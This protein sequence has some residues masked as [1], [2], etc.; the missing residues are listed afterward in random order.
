[1]SSVLE[2]IEGILGPQAPGPIPSFSKIHVI[3]VLDTLYRSGPMGRASLARAVGLGEGAIRTMLGRL[4]SAGLVEVSRRGCRLTEE[5]LELWRSLSSR[6]VRLGEVERAPVGARGFA[7]LV[8][9]GAGRVRLGVEQ[10]DEAVR[11]GA[12][13]AIT[14]VVR[15]GKLVMPGISDDVD[16][17]YPEFSEEL[18]ALARPA[19]GDAIV[20]AFAGDARLAEYG[21]LAAALSLL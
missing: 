5:G 10:R 15:E 6:L 2:I 13:G 1:M 11:A 18:R 16:S 21:A 17:D 9:E 7:Y 14:L 8:R 4:S 3:M 20:I 19:E 12:D